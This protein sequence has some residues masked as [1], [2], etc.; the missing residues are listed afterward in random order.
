MIPFQ[1]RS[2]GTFHNG[3]ALVEQ[4]SGFGVI[5]RQG[6]VVLPMEY[7][8][9]EGFEGHR[10]RLRKAGRMGLVSE[11]GDRVLQPVHDHIGTFND[12]L[13]MVVTNGKCGYVDTTG[14]F[15][16][17]QE[18][19]ANTDVAA[20]GDFRGGLAEVQLQGKRGLINTRNERIVPCQYVDIGG[21]NGPFFPVKKKAKW[22]YMD[23]KG[24]TVIEAKYDQAWDFAGGLARVK[25]GDAFGALDSTGKE[26]IPVRFASLMDADHGHIV[27]G[28]SDGVGLLDITG[29]VV[30]PA[31]YDS[32]EL[33]NERIAKV[34]ID[35]KFGYLRLADR[36][37]IW[38]EKGFEKAAS[39]SAE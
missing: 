37:F 30:I 35:E 18:Y 16:I 22:G 36:Q 12:G 19:E 4:Q 5:D 28:E 21:T 29:K 25:V 20:W 8:W 7:E 33:V 34:E 9:V 15:V 11:F 14:R 24:N 3:L 1:F 27:A 13:A 39:D 38:K 26:I 10:S 17:P 23:R 31:L 2:A 6:G 32:V